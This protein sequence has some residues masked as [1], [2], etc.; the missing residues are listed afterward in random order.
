MGEQRSF[1]CRDPEGTWLER[2]NVSNVKAKSPSAGR[3][4]EELREAGWK[5]GGI[6]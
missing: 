5:I 4:A 3:V 2:I 6:V 1:P